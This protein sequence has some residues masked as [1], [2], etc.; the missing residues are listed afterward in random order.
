MIEFFPAIKQHADPLDPRRRARRR[1]LPAAAAARRRRPRRRRRGDGDER[2]HRRAD[3]REPRRRDPR[4]DRRR[5]VLRDA[6]AR[7]G[8]DR[9]SCSA[10][11]STARSPPTPR[12]NRHDFLVALDRAPRS[13]RRARRR[14]DERRAGRAA[15]C[16]DRPVANGAEPV[17][18]RSA[19]APRD[20]ACDRGA[21]ARRRSSFAPGLAIGSFL[22][23]VAARLPL[24][25]RSSTPALG[26]PALRTRRSVV[27]TTSRS[28]RTLLLRGR[29]RAA[30]VRSRGATRPSSSSR[31]R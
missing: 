10:G 11:A 18:G 1:R 9:R 5:R 23:V 3:P 14:S 20:R 25:A 16:A 26:V 8:A 7:A 2:P 21:C 4:R 15:R 17:A 31:P 27:A 12:P 19:T 22:N 24:G 28:S 30:G 13:T 29:C 6:D